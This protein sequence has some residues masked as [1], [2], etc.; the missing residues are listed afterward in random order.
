MAVDSLNSGRQILVV[1]DQPELVEL[2]EFILD[3]HGFEPI[4]AY[5][6]AKAVELFHKRK[7]DLVLLDILLG[8]S[9]GLQVLQAIRQSSAVPVIMLTAL[10]QLEDKVRGLELGAD[11]YLTKPFHYQEL[12]ARIEALLRR[13]RCNMTAEQRRPSQL[14]VGSLVLDEDV[15]EVTKNGVFV[16]LPPKEFDLLR[17]LMQRAGRVVHYRTL[18]QEVWNDPGPSVSDVVRVTLH[19]LRQKLEDDP[20]HPVLLQIIPRIG[21]KLKVEP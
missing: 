14:K 17:C 19:R 21:V 11:D 16:D 8:R 9:N 5:E 18:Q 7:P 13:S 10:D 2:L 4:L 15:H 12:V 6:A 1:D 3:Q 20:S